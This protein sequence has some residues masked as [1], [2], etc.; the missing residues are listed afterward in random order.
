MVQNYLKQLLSIV[1]LSIC[2]I[3]FFV[4]T[5]KIALRYFQ[6]SV[7]VD[8][9]IKT[10]EEDTV[11][12]FTIYFRHFKKLNNVSFDY[13][14]KESTTATQNLIDSCIL[15]MDHRAMNCSDVVIS[16]DYEFIYYTFFRRNFSQIKNNSFVYS[17]HSNY[18]N[19]VSIQLKKL[20]GK[21]IFMKI[22]SPDS[23]PTRFDSNKI[24]FYFVANTTVE[25]SYG[26]TSVTF[27]PHPYPSQC[28]D[29]KRRGFANQQNC[30]DKCCEEKSR[31][32]CESLPFETSF[33]NGTQGYFA[34]KTCYFNKRIDSICT[35][36]CSNVDCE[37]EFYETK[38]VRTENSENNAK[39]ALNIR[40]PKSRLFT[41][42]K[43]RALFTFIEVLLYAGNTASSWLAFNAFLVVELV[44]YRRNGK[45]KVDTKTKNFIQHEIDLILKVAALKARKT[46]HY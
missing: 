43:T 37:I 19:L 22:H 25:I 18:E 5:Y 16:I 29:Y 23:S 24:Y 6:Y 42:Y 39:Q 26:K 21:L 2:S 9:F 13:A 28:V 11:P 33:R 31:K 34:D 7:I 30:F 8:V 12:G 36:R 1:I 27:L 40:K 20:R 15:F 10:L 44:S 3:I 17:I 35:K 46:E 45:R 4:L 38:N 32:E 41:T 14:F